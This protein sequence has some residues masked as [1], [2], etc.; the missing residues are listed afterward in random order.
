MMNN[1]GKMTFTPYYCSRLSCGLSWWAK[2]GVEVKSCPR[3]G[4]GNKNIVKGK[5]K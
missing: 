5:E 3:P 2:K 1:A 4:C